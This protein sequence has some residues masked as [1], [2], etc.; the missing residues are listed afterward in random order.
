[1]NLEKSVLP[2][3]AA[4][5]LRKERAWPG[6][7]SPVGMGRWR[8]VGD[9]KAGIPDEGGGRNGGEREGEMQALTLTSREHK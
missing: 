5:A 7:W 4:Q 3:R 9:Q 6:L 8:T 2:L 1:M